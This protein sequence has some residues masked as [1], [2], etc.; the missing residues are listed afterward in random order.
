VKKRIVLLIDSLCQGGAQRQITTL[1]VRLA[2]AGHHV[3]L[4]MYHPFDFFV[5]E[6]EAAGVP[7]ELVRLPHKLLR[8]PVFYHR[9]RA[10]QPDAVIAFLNTPT[11]LADLAAFPRSRFRVIV[12]ER[13]G[14]L[15][16]PR[17]G[18]KTRFQLHRLA[19]AVVTNGQHLADAVTQTAPWLKAKTHV[20]INCVDL[21]RFHP[22]EEP[23]GD[24][25][26]IA[27]LA[28]V[29]AEKNPMTVMRALQ[30]L[31][32]RR[33]DLSITLDWYGSRYLVNGEPTPASATWLELDQALTDAEMHGVL[34]IHDPVNDVVPIYQGV[35]LILL[36]SAYEGCPN[37]ICEAIA[38]GRPVLACR[39]CDNHRLVHEGA[40]GYLF[41]P[42]DPDQLADALERFAD[43][44]PDQRTAMGH[45]SRRI[46]EDLLSPQTFLERYEHLIEGTWARHRP[47]GS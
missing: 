37:V 11:I 29:S 24:T 41:D 31:R 30:R 14:A 3:R 46:A 7:V 45:A 23:E 43:L 12:S 20:I 6:L 42:T 8:I 13:T 32:D 25:I 26:R 38:C 28:R 34:R 47:D 1:G 44:T 9:L 15:D 36:A 10:L 19:D 2:K 5:P 39:I 22:T 35:S 17:P 40:N 33:P 21:E 16:K 4:L 18:D 27:V